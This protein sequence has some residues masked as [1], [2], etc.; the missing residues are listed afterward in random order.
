[1]NFKCYSL[2]RIGITMGGKWS[3]WVMVFGDWVKPVATSKLSNVCGV[4]S[5]HEGK[6]GLVRG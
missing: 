4:Y 6:K 3:P 2:V 5:F 1:M